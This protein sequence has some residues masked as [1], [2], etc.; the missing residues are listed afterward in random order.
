MRVT[1][2]AV[3]AAV[4]GALLATPATAQPAGVAFAD[5]DFS[6]YATS[7]V[8]HLHL[9][10]Q[11][12]LRL[13]N[14]DAAFTGAAVDSTGLG[15]AQLNEVKRVVRPAAEGAN[16]GKKT[17]ARGSGLEVGL[18]LNPPSAPGQL[19]LQGLAQAW[20]PPTSTQN[21]VIGPVNVN[22]LA[23]ASTLR[24]NAT[25][26]WTDDSTCVLGTDLSRGFAHVENLQ[27]VGS[28][29]NNEGLTNPL[30]GTFAPQNGRAIS[31]SVSRTALVP[32]RN[33]AGQPIGPN[34]GLISQTRQT[35]A[36]VTLFAGTT[37]ETRIEFLGEWVLTVVATGI[38]GGAYVHYGPG[39]V[40]PETLVANIVRAG[41]DVVR[42]RLQQIT[43]NT[44]LVV[45]LPSGLG[46]IAI[47]E[48]P[49]AI[50]GNAASQPEIAADGTSAAAAVDVVRIRLTIPGVEV[51]DLRIGHMEVRAQVPAGGIACALPVTKV[52]TPDSVSVGDNFTTT[53]TINN[54]YDC[55]LVG[56]V[57][58]DE[59]TTTGGARFRVV[60]TT[61]TADQVPGGDNLSSGTVRWSLPDPL[62]PGEQTQ[63]AVT[64]QAQGSS[65]R[66][67]DIAR[68]TGALANC[69][70]EDASVA[71]TAIS[72][73]G[74]GLVGSSDPVRVPVGAVAPQVLARTGPGAWLTMLSGLS[75]LGVSLAGLRASRRRLS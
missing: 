18:A 61:P 3:V 72:A 20:A 47:G 35:I 34:F 68:A 32:Q 11:G 39:A 46:E 54:P 36:P 15:A 27:L 67:D 40:N 31:N 55:D 38:D 16:A 4:V 60:S 6:G 22:N 25:A 51:T 13:E 73:A 23:Y 1:C 58:N 45:P 2:A 74:A 26:R 42:V 71:G 8:A 29:G 66:I 63:V 75:L 12:Q 9:V 30:I 59:I 49:R 19:N 5:A 56:I 28:G 43:G 69:R 24:G 44:G 33:A 53:I 50:G 57:V 64:L 21:Q 7:T 65:G 10:E 52:A 62:G 48:D 14:T 37:N 70:G 17:Y 41:Q